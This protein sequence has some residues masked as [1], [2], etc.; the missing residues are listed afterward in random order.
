MVESTDKTQLGDRMKGYE[1]V[2]TARKFSGRLPVYARIDGRSFSKFTKTMKK[3]YDE[4]MSRAMI[5][6]TRYAVK[7]TGA[8]MGYTQSDEISLCW[9]ADDV[10]SSLF[11]DGKIQKMASNISSLI[12]AAF[13]VEALKVF[14]EICAQRLPSFDC[15]VIEMP[16]LEEVANMFLWREMDATK[17]SIS[18]AA[19]SEFS[20]QALKGKNGAEKIKM[21]AEKGIDWDSYPVFFKRGTFLA[22][23]TF[24]TVMTPEELGKIPEAHRDPGRVV[25]RSSIV[26]VEMPAFKTVENRVDVIFHGA[27]PV[28][29][30][31]S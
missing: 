22:R 11:F 26:E 18:M 21:L 14:P 24:D 12:T 9:F 8:S 20:D 28:V 17:N 2:E 19:Y 15:R 5:E 3:P 30:E 6:A 4:A 1:R 10:K 25:T 13:L 16:S 23:K 29:R 7:Q 27:T 31:D